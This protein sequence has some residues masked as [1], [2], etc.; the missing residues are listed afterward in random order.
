[1]VFVGPFDHPHETWDYCHD[2]GRF[3]RDS[4]FGAPT[5]DDPD[6]RERIYPDAARPG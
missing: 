3:D 2:I 6:D 5:T 1:V 4:C